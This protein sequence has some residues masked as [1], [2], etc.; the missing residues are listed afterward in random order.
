MYIAME[1]HSFLL[2]HKG[3]ERIVTNKNST[4]MLH[5]Y[6]TM[7]RIGGYFVVDVRTNEMCPWCLEIL[8]ARVNCDTAISVSDI[9]ARAVKRGWR[10]VVSNVD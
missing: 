9:D 4:E 6:D 2:L 1:V 10:F 3:S 7:Y 5:F 8:F